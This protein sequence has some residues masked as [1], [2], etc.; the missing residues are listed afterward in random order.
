MVQ[1]NFQMLEQAV[2]DSD[3]FAKLFGITTVSDSTALSANH[4]FNLTQIAQKMK[5]GTNWQ[6]AQGFINQITNDAGVNIKG[7]DNKYHRAEKY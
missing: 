7:S 5:K 3:G 4:P 1:A 6:Y 2:N